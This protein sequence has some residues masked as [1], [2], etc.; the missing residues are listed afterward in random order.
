MV[1]FGGLSVWQ[2]NRQAQSSLA[3]LDILEA[4]P[5]ILVDTI[6]LL[7]VL[8]ALAHCDDNSI[9]LSPLTA[10]VARGL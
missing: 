2:T 9:V 6:S 1:L 4:S 7:S 5:A 8:A 3:G 10:C